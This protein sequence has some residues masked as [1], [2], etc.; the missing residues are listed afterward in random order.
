LGGPTRVHLACCT[1]IGNTVKFTATRNSGFN[2][3]MTVKLLKNLK[4][5]IV[6]F[7]VK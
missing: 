1:A 6:D 2:S 3:Q 4:F 7:T 5:S